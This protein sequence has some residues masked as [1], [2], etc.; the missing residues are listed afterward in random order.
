MTEENIE[1]NEI[2]IRQ[3]VEDTEEYIRL[4]RHC[5]DPVELDNV[6]ELYEDLAAELERRS[7]FDDLYN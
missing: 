6:S 7:L 1:M 2:A 5:L 3:F 4:N